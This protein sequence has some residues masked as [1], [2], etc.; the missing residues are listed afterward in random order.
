MRALLRGVD[1][2]APLQDFVH[3]SFL[4]LHDFDKKKAFELFRKHV[5]TLVPVV[6][7][8][9]KLVNVITLKE[10]IREVGFL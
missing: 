1:I 6:D 7:N 2:H 3:G 4:F 9:F 10:V 5:I 8:N